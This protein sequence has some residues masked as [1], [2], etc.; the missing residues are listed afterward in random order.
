MCSK[1]SVGPRMVPWET[2][3]L[4]GCSQEDFSFRTMWSHLLLRKE[5]IRPHIWPETP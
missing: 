1:E 2:L 3:E 4:T 5:E